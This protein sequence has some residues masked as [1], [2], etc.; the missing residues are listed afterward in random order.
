LV[1]G[2]QLLDRCARRRAE[3]GSRLVA[4]WADLA[5]RDV[6]RGD[7]G[8]RVRAADSDGEAAAIAVEQA[9]IEGRQGDRVREAARISAVAGD[10]S[11]PVV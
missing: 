1:E 10:S 7:L 3:A 4:Q 6:E 9:Q 11:V 2:A 5:G 8:R